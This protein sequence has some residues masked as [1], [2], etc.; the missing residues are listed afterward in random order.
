MVY[1]YKYKF[2]TQQVHI[3]EIERPH[4]LGYVSYLNKFKR[5]M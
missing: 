2:Y 3:F 4:K 5:S 1:V